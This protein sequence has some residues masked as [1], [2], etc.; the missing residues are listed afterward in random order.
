MKIVHCLSTGDTSME[1]DEEKR[2]PSDKIDDLPPKMRKE[3]AEVKR[4]HR[5]LLKRLVQG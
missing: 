5:K 1:R 3:Y 4:Y 2:A